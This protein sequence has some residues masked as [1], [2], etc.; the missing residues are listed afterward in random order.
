[1]ASLGKKIAEYRMNRSSDP[2]SGYRYLYWLRS[3]QCYRERGYPPFS[4]PPAV[5][6]CPSFNPTIGISEI[7][8]HLCLSMPFD[9]EPLKQLIVDSAKLEIL[10]LYQQTESSTKPDGSL[11]TAADIALQRRVSA[12]LSR[13]YPDIP[14]L[15]EE[16]SQEEQRELL[17]DASAGFWCL[18]PLDGTSNFVAGMPCFAVSLAYLGQGETKLGII[19][20]PI[21]NECFSALSG[22]GAWLNDR[23]LSL[24][25]QATQLADCVAMVDLKRLP[26]D[27]ACNLATRPPYR[28]QRNIG[29][30]ALEWCWLAAGRVQLYLHGGQ[31]LWDY[32]AGRLIFA[33]AGGVHSLA[34]GIERSATYT[35][36]LR[37]KVAMAAL[38]QGLFDSWTEWIEQHQLNNA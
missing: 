15:G 18:D 37:P 26:A 1:M 24:N 3:D 33:E 19:Y 31:R 36:D 16:M 38:T 22:Q 12:S 28:S 7:S 10:P 2:A 34:D 27:L 29:S 6:Q 9:I 5:R 32:A 13:L 17:A 21:R 4:P 35:Q 8:H 25:V 14:F 30:V 11:I 20:D 23:R